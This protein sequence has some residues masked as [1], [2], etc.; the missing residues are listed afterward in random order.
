MNVRSADGVSIHYSSRGSG[1]PALLFVH[2]WCCDETYW[3]PQVRH[4]AERHRVVSIDLAGHGESGT[5]R[6]NWSVNA[7]GEDVAAV[8]KELSLDRVILVGHSMGGPVIVEAARLMPERVIGLVGVDTFQDLD[9]KQTRAPLDERLSRFRNSFVEASHEVVKSM[10]AE[11]SDPELAARIVADM[12]SSPSHVGIGAIEAM[13]DYDAAKA[14]E[15]IQ[16]PIRCVCSDYQ[17]FDTEAADQ[18]SSSFKVTFMS[19]VGHFVMLEDPATFN[20]LLEEIIEELA[21]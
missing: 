1:S 6:K 14:M 2:G 17:P 20:R 5:D 15:S 4:F 9:R 8:V 13:G 7:F 10:F 21:S 19:G 16:V 3:E 11:K 12:S 18:H